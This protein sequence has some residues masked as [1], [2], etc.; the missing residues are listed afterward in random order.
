M[1]THISFSSNITQNAAEFGMLE[2]SLFSISSGFTVCEHN[3]D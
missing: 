3:N 2:N 1:G